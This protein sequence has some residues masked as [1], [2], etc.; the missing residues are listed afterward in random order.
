MCVLHSI[1]KIYM[2]NLEYTEAILV[3]STLK[4]YTENLLSSIEGK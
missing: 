2:C 3:Y 4:R 1:E